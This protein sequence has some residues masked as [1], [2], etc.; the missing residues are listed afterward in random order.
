MLNSYSEKIII[1]ESPEFSDTTFFDVA[2]INLD[3]NI[4]VCMETIGIP[5]KVK[6][7]YSDRVRYR[8]RRSQMRD[9]R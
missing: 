3:G 5:A 2:D 1:T 9:G 7:R 4:D 6:P 8:Q